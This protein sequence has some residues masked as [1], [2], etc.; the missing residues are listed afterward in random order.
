MIRSGGE[1]VFAVE[2]E[3][4]LM[5]DPKVQEA[6]VIGLPDERWGERVVAVV[7]PRPGESLDH[8]LIRA[9]CREHLA[10]YKVPK[11]VEIVHELPRTGL[12]KVAKHDLR[13]RLG[14]AADDGRHAGAPLTFGPAEG[15][16]AG[17][18]GELEP[19]AHARPPVPT[20]GRRSDRAA[21]GC[22]CPRRFR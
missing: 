22:R 21:A 2:V 18:E 13:A 3:R 17:R 9:W 19:V 10:A 11:Q 6:A 14:A 20:M 7:V 12:G 16:L 4:V 5:T 15:L 1:N 8:D